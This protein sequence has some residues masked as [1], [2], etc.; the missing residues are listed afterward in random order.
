[1]NISI[2]Y[3]RDRVFVGRGRTGGIFGDG[4]SDIRV[5]SLECSPVEAAAVGLDAV[6]KLG[7]RS[8]SFED[9]SSISA[10][11][12][13]LILSFSLVLPSTLLRFETSTSPELPLSRCKRFLAAL[14]GIPDL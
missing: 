9:A 6:D 2:C 1:M 8:K 5:G 3:A 4:E 12:L 10:T 7:N 14:L 13:L 11:G